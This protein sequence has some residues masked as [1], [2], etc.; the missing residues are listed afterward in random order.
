MRTSR[1]SVKTSLGPGALGALLGLSPDG[2]VNAELGGRLPPAERTPG[3]H[4]RWDP[5]AVAAWLRERGASVP[6]ALRRAAGEACLRPAEP[7]KH[8]GDHDGTPVVMVVPSTVCPCQ[9]HAID[10]GPGA[11]EAPRRARRAS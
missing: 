3:G 11:S 2:V 4:R 9:S 1:D 5:A 7:A 10:P 8:E 6:A